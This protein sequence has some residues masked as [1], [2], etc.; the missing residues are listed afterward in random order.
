[1]QEP[2]LAQEKH[3]DEEE[4]ELLR[5]V[6]FLCGFLLWVELGVEVILLLRWYLQE[7]ATQKMLEQLSQCFAKCDALRSSRLI[8][9][10]KMGDHLVQVVLAAQVW[11]LILLSTAKSVETGT[12]LLILVRKR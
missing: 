4:V 9:I 8:S 5:L 12:P 7:A 3:P 1:M 6:W 10:C 11:D 2:D